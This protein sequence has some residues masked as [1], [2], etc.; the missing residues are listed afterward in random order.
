M[1]CHRTSP[2]GPRDESWRQVDGVSA[3]APG[4]PLATPQRFTL[5]VDDQVEL[6]AVGQVRWLVKKQPAVVHACAQR[7]HRSTLR[8]Q[9]PTPQGPGATAPGSRSER[10]TG[11]FAPSCPRHAPT[12]AKDDTPAHPAPPRPTRSRLEKSSRTPSP[13]PRREQR[14]PPRFPPTNQQV[15]RSSRARRATPHC[16]RRAAHSSPQDQ[17][18]QRS[19]R[20]RSRVVTR[21]NS[22]ISFVKLPVTRRGVRVRRWSRLARFPLSDAPGRRKSTTW[23]DSQL[24]SG[25]VVRVHNG[26]NRVKPTPPAEVPCHELSDRLPRGR[27]SSNSASL[28]AP[29]SARIKCREQWRPA[30]TAFPNSAASCWTCC[31]RSCGTQASHDRHPGHKNGGATLRSRRRCP[32]VDASTC[33]SRCHGRAPLRCGT[34]TSRARWSLHSRHDRSP[35][36]LDMA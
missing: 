20:L 26:R 27:S 9:P 24:T 31:G 28:L 2:E 12:A 22:H 35:N 17:R 6:Q 33:T 36:T 29:S 19:A 1:C 18:N 34:F 11:D 5:V 16:F 30:S 4:G 14:L 7:T 10:A 8:V 21:R 25:D 32:A 15:A 13:T 23:L 3:R